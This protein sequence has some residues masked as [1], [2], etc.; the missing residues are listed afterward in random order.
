MKNVFTLLLAAAC[1]TAT[2]QLDDGSIAPDFIA[3]DIYG[4]EHHLYSYLEQG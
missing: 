1:F 4:N 3:T 2:A